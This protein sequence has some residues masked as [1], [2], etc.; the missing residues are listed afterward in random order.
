MQNRDSVR[1]NSAVVHIRLGGLWNPD[2]QKR[3]DLAPHVKLV[4]YGGGANMIDWGPTPYFKGYTHHVNQMDPITLTGMNDPFQTGP[5]Y[6]VYMVV[7]PALLGRTGVKV[8]AGPRPELIQAW[9]R[10]HNVIYHKSS[11]WFLDLSFAEHNMIEGYI[12]NSEQ[13]FEQLKSTLVEKKYMGPPRC[14]DQAPTL[15]VK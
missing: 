11:R 5:L 10:H 15:G 13:A 12:C 3:E 4:T 9:M 1:L 2:T 8:V 7:G 6:P 14:N